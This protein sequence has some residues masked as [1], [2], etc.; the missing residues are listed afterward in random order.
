[1]KLTP[2]ALRGVRNDSGQ[3]PE[4]ILKRLQG[5][6]EIHYGDLALLV[7]ADQFAAV[8]EYVSGLDADQRRRS[9]LSVTSCLARSAPRVLKGNASKKTSDQLYADLMLWQALK[10]AAAS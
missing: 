10:E 5:G 3:S 8:K 4:A 9:M 7:Q 1:M 2:D 6:V